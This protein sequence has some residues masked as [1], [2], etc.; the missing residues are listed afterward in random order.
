MK[1]LSGL[2]ISLLVFP[3]I[4]AGCQPEQK[5]ITIF[6]GAASKPALDEV[7]R[8]FEKQTGIKVYANYG[9]SG[10]VLSQMK[11][12]KTGDLYIPGSPDFMVKAE[13]DGVVEPKTVKIISYL[14][15]VIAVQRGNPKNIQ[16][17][18]DLARPGLK[19]G[20]ADPETVCVGLYAI[21][22]LEYNR[23][24]AEVGKN[25]ITYTE[26]CEKTATILSL[27]SVDAV[28][29]WHV[30]R[31]WDPDRIDVVYLRPEQLPRIA[32]IPAAISTFTKDREN[33]WK[34]M[35]FLVSPAGGD[36]FRKWGYIA[37]EAEAKKF[38]PGATIGGEYRLPETYKPL[39][40]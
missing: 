19:I 1:R 35:D 10:T 11:L 28:I 40:K 38:A 22:I 26:S 9:G 37:T 3:L 7:A 17:L 12:A 30:F 29:G 21:E 4:L 8:A 36:M 16:T 32:Y 23:L 5:T 20:I 25:V 15:P 18:S 6:A 14:I 31:D 24:L 34:F 33:A 2:L 13:R 39:V 27:K